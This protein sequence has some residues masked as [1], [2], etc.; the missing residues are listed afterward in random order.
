MGTPL[1]SLGAQRQQFCK[2]VNQYLRQMEAAMSGE[3]E[4]LPL[5]R[6][7][8]NS[9][10]KPA[11]DTR[12]R[13]VLRQRDLIFRA[14]VETTKAGDAIGLETRAASSNQ[15]VGA[16]KKNK[17]KM[18]RGQMDVVVGDSVAVHD[19]HEGT[20]IYRVVETHGTD[21]KCAEMPEEWLGASRWQFASDIA[22][23]KAGDASLTLK[24][25]IRANRGDELAIFPSYRVFCSCVQQ[26][27][28]AW[29]GPAV[30]LLESYHAQTQVVSQRVA[31][32]LLAYASN[33]RVERFFIQTA[34]RVLK[35]LEAAARRELELLLQHEARPY[36]Q[37][38]HL[39]EELDRRR[40]R[41]LRTRLEAALPSGDERGLVSL[42]DVTRA[43][44]D[45][46][47]GSFALPS[48]DREALEME[49][50]LRAY[51]DVASRRFVD[52]VPMKLNG[53]LL[54]SFL[55]E[56]ER[57]LLGATTDEKVAQLLRESDAKATKR[58][59][60]VDQV[61]TLE[62]AR[63]VIEDSGCW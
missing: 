29:E 18:L 27:V 32:V 14:E 23:T 54:A 19:A 58:Q 43:L 38:R 11:V 57:E 33:P 13:A 17:L 60:L 31:S 61:L 59:Q 5:R 45:I 49:V 46:V 48:D 36:T 30:R 42:A 52:V 35:A 21:V 41:A 24:Q 37:D 12:L 26:S 20:R 50:A 16:R 1:E 63:S 62:D 7:S 28:R 44:G 51:L 6:V 10:S 9:V 39:Y 47:G 3:Y 4:P 34:D 53:L 2:W 40:Q 55:H 56:M 8:S 15:S 22:A 25:F